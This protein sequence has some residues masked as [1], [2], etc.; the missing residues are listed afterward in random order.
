MRSRFRNSAVVTTLLSVLICF[1][2]ASAQSTNQ[3]F[4][5]PITSS[6]ISGTIKPRDVGDARLTSYFFQFDG[7]QG[8]LFIN[9]V[10]KNFA[11][12]VDVF[13]QN[14]L[15]PLTKVVLYADYGEN[16]T[17]RVIYLRKP[18]KMILRVQGRTPG[19]EAAT[20]RIKFAGSFVASSQA[21][22][23]AEPT[24]PGVTAKNDSGI[25]V[26]SVGTIVEVIP[27]ATPIPA[28]VETAAKSIEEKDRPADVEKRELAAEPKTDEKAPAEVST[29]V[30]EKKHEVV[31]TDNIPEKTE[32]IPTPPASTRT[33]RSRRGTPPKTVAK[34]EP[35][36]TDAP[37][38]EV[39][40]TEKPESKTASSAVK[41]ATTRRGRAASTPPATGTPDPLEKI[42]LVIQFKDGST[43]QRPMSE[44]LRFSVDKGVLTV[45]SKDGSTGRY[46]ILEVTKVTIE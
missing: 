11:G 35:T 21:E 12:D 39:T 26:N 30:P 16:E 6:E 24:L 22:P 17:G 29:D 43:I 9:I 8:D 31:V 5:T 46:S 23:A 28:P 34:P 3:D 13:T 18:E 33:S 20:F 19:D 4:P 27:K 37:T 14:G 15:R 2:A 36:E 7:S 1:A 32:I 41:P 45:V 44:V 10:T 42:N 40:A 25:R 38:G